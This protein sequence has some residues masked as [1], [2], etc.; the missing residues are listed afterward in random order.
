LQCELE[1]IVYNYFKVWQTKNVIL[2]TL[3]I[4]KQNDQQ[5]NH[6][7]KSFLPNIKQAHFSNIAFGLQVIIT[8]SPSPIV[9]TCLQ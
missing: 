3:Y 6:H 2:N 7:Q 4:V 9:V 1:N 5:K 8:N